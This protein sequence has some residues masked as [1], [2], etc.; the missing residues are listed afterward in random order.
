MDNNPSPIKPKPAHEILAR[1]SAVISSEIT[2]QLPDLD[3]GDIKA[4]LETAAI[5]MREQAEL[6]NE[7]SEVLVETSIQT[8][9]DLDPNK[10]LVVDDVNEN[11][12]LIEYLFKNTEFSLSLADD[13]K[14]ALVKARTEH[15]ILIIS[16]VMM[17]QMSGFEL[18]TA[19]KEDERTKNIGIIL[20]TAHHR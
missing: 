15:P 10:I 3:P 14:E 11:L 17:P 20:V 2:E 16:D 12:F 9:V 13:A 1:L 7:E 6:P 8:T 19:L 4:A 5:S 18:L